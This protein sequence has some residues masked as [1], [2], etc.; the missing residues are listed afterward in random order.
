MTCVT[1]SHNTRVG[2]E[3]H[4]KEG[5]EELALEGIIYNL[6]DLMQKVGGMQMVLG[7]SC[8]RRV[9]ISHAGRLRHRCHQSRGR[10]VARNITYADEVH[11]V[12]KIEMPPPIA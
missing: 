9:R 7:L 5:H 11:A 10:T 1:G 6:I 12:T 3:E 2:V 8:A 4:G